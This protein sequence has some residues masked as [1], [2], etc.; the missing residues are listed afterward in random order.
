MSQAG[1]NNVGGIVSYPITVPNGGTGQVSLPIH[2]V[3]LGQG[4]AA[5]G[6]AGPGALGSVLTGQGAG[7][8]PVFSTLEA[9]VNMDITNTGGGTITFNAIPTPNSYFSFVDDFLVW[10][11][12]G[13]LFQSSYGWSRANTDTL[14]TL[15]TA[16]HPGIVVN[17]DVASGA[18][19]IYTTTPGLALKV[20]AGE[21]KCNWV[22]KLFTLSNS[23][24]RYTLRCGFGDV[25]GNEA[26]NGIYFEYSDNKNDGNWI[27]K[28]SESSTRASLNSA[29][30]VASDW[31]N[32]G[33]VINAAGTSVEYF[34]DGVSIGTL[35]T[36]I[37]TSGIG[38]NIHMRRE[39]GTIQPESIAVDLVY[40]SQQLTTA[41]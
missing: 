38:P 17:T 27:G 31:V 32:V 9:G 36:N 3:L 39:A 19:S 16:G 11:T 29:T 12:S 26:T 15:A 4:T 25:S 14:T 18:F 24:N 2:T 37:P 33:F 35:N 34:V 5:I 41:R 20:G 23:T 6:N 13:S 40:I 8:D 22:F 10:Q 30:A 7:A 1:S 28:T 21:I